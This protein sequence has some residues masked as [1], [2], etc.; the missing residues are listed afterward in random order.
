MHKYIISAYSVLIKKIGCFSERIENNT[1]QAITRL[2]IFVLCMLGIIRHFK[3][4]L[5]EIIHCSDRTGIYIGAIALFVILVTSADQNTDFRKLN[6]N[7]FCLYGWLLCFIMIFIM[8]FINP[9]RRGYFVWSIVSL[10]VSVP[11]VM[12][13]ASRDDFPQFCRL[14]ARVMTAVAGCFVILNIVLVPFISAPDSDGY[15]GLM[16]NPNGNGMICT[17]LYAACFF[18]LLTEEKDT[19]VF[20][21]I[22]GFC[23]AFCFVSKCRTAQIA[24]ALESITGVVYYLR[25]LKTEGKTHSARK[26]VMICAIIIGTALAGSFILEKIGSMDLNAYALDDPGSVTAET[27]ELFNTLDQVSSGRARVWRRFISEATFWGNGSPQEPL[28]PWYEASLY[29]HNNAIEILYTSG[30]PAFIGY[31]IFLIAGIVFVIRCITG[32]NGYG[33]ENILVVMAFTGYFVEAMLEVVMYPMCHMPAIL[34]NL[35]MIPIFIRNKEPDNPAH[36]TG[37]KDA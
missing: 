22:A 17:G 35:C 21:V 20:S 1:K 4:P 24:I 12:V 8:S 14:L 27:E 31:T 32:K 34:L 10:L 6:I 5:K 13:W 2:M 36:T 3:T 19:L 28:M 25:C 11:F 30:V 26:A 33:K 9:V 18:L 37:G 23:I 29:A 15:F 7:K 16:I